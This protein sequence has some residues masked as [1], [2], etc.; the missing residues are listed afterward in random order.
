MRTTR[1][2]LLALLGL[3]LLTVIGCGEDRPG[4]P[5]TQPANNRDTAGPGLQSPVAAVAD[6][7]KALHADIMRALS[8]GNLDEAEAA[9]K[10]AEALTG[11]DAQMAEQIRQAREAFDAAKAA[12][13]ISDAANV[14]PPEVPEPP[15]AVEDIAAKAAGL[16][17]KVTDLMAQKNLTEAESVLAELEGLSGSVSQDLQKQITG[18]REKLNTAKEVGAVVPGGLPFK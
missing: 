9:L 4:Q 17:Q 10:E 2:L 3:G 8:A 5:A 13:A 18:L 16:I 6:K 1:T 12:K 11:V 7:A 14:A 15:K